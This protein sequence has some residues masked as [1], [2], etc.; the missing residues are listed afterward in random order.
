M[1]IYLS[2]K[3]SIDEL[4]FRGLNLTI[5]E[6]NAR[7]HGSLTRMQDWSGSSTSSRRSKSSISSSGSSRSRQCRRRVA[8]HSPPRSSPLTC[9]DEEAI[10][11]WGECSQTACKPKKPSRSGSP[12]RRRSR[13][14]KEEELSGAKPPSLPPRRTSHDYSLQQS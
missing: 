14:A 3:M 7:G 9:Q 8:S 5:L 4:P 12:Q 2:L 11:R 13:E 10:C 1:V 6:D